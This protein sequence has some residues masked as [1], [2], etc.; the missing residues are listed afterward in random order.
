MGAINITLAG[1]FGNHRSKQFSAME[2]GHAAAVSEAIKYLAEVELPKAIENDHRCHAD[3][4]EPS[5]G[6]AGAGPIVKK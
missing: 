3:G 4:I 2:K 6:F 1:S 5:A